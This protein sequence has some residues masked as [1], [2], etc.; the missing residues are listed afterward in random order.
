MNLINNYFE[1]ITKSI[2]SIMK[3]ID[4]KI[5]TQ[6]STLKALGVI[7]S[8]VIVAVVVS[9]LEPKNVGVYFL[10]FA[11]AKVFSLIFSLG[12]FAAIIPIYASSSEDNANHTISLAVISSL[13]MASLIIIVINSAFYFIPED[14]KLS[15]CYIPY[16]SFL[17]A[18][19]TIQTNLFHI[20]SA[21]SRLIYATLFQEGTGRNTLLIV[22][23]GS[24]I[25]FDKNLLE[26]KSIIALAIISTFLL[27]IFGL[28]N[29]KFY[30]NIFKVPLS[31]AKKFFKLGLNFA[32][33]TAIS[34]G[35]SHIIEIFINYLFGPVALAALALGNRVCG[36][37]LF[38][39][40]MINLLFVRASKI[41]FD[42]RF[43]E[44]KILYKR[45]ILGSLS[46]ALFL[47]ICYIFF[48][49]S[50][51]NDFLGIDQIK[52]ADFAIKA[53]L[54]S[55]IGQSIAIFSLAFL[56]NTGRYKFILGLDA[57]NLT[58][59]LI[60]LSIGFVYGNAL[61]PIIIIVC[62]RIIRQLL[63]FIYL[64]YLLTNQKDS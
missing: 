50:L 20:F 35:S 7:S 8:I 36:V 63:S 21:Q 12:S 49:S 45:C 32:P 16:A 10:T 26:V 4:F 29:I 60:L 39:T 13:I 11:I 23:I 3:I 2:K 25:I 34:N 57:L 61:I 22:L 18:A 52:N 30:L 5:L 59:A 19:V 17:G 37:F 40:Q 1:R 41:Y 47:I 46:S 38:F 27:V 55:T 28:L 58:L 15:Y 33:S 54:L 56:K 62:L 43:N 51:A 44:L 64:E 24:I 9:E 48:G 53:M 14:I 42:G 31:I 6:L